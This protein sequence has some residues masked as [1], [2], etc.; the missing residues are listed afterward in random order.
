MKNAKNN[1]KNNKVV[2]E[3]F[4]PIT[5]SCTVTEFT[6]GLKDIAE[7]TDER[8]QDLFYDQNGDLFDEVSAR[9]ALTYW[10]ADNLPVFGNRETQFNS[11]KCAYN[12]INVQFTGYFSIGWNSF[13]DRETKE[14]KYTFFY[15]IASDRIKGVVYDELL[16]RGWSEL[17]N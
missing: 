15:T 12:K 14:M 8:Y 10:Y 17:N 3:K 1:T 11:M 5:L 7:V 16:A 13:I 4:D 6:E 9:S 2:K